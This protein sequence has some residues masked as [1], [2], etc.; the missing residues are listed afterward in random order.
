MIV[1][2]ESPA[3]DAK[4]APAPGADAIE[5]SAALEVSRALSAS[6]RIPS[7]RFEEMFAR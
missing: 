3:K 5:T 1:A 4:L 7:Q 6:I 2:S